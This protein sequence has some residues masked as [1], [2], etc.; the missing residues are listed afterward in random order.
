MSIWR[1]IFKEIWHRKRAAAVAV[2]VLAASVAALCGTLTALDLHD[3]HT[4]HLMAA[5]EKQ[6][7]DQMAALN[8]EMR[9]A[10]LKLSFNVIILPAEQNLRDWY[11]NDYADKYMPEDYADRLVRANVVTVQHLLPS[12]QQRV[13]WPEQNGRTIVLIGTR[14]EV[15]PAHDNPKKPLVQP[16]PPGMIVLGHELQQTTGANVGDKLRLLG[17]E[18]TV[19]ACQEERGTKDDVTAWIPLDEAQALLGKEGQVNAIM[20]LQCMCAGT[21]IGNIRREVQ[22]VLPD[23]QIVE[24]G[25][26]VLARY[27]ARARVG[28]EAKAAVQSERQERAG[29]RAE[30]ES[31]AS[32]LVPL[33]MLAAAAWLGLTAFRD[34]RLRRKEYGILRAMGVRSTRV[35]WL[36]LSKAVVL[37]MLGGAF[38][39]LAGV[40]LGSYVGREVE[41]AVI[42]FW[43]LFEPMSIVIALGVA[44]A[45]SVLATWIPAILAARSD[46][47]VILREG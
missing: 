23:I 13:Q 39:F 44:V 18:F 21:D 2:I 41:Q 28:E 29:Q 6:V 24:M 11:T 46:P 4:E 16:V 25:T 30:R 26:P 12:L 1:L 17:R 3:R 7:A 15:T 35:L 9:K 8:E 20:A 5:R 36:F 43:D 47:A 32:V 19:H 45:I 34:V 33:L 10:T 40:W 38:G 37:G 14:G 22:K 27:E 42:P 31:L